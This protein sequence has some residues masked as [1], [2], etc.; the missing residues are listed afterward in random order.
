MHFHGV[1]YLINNLHFKSSFQVLCSY[2]KTK[3]EFLA[4]QLSKNLEILFFKSD[5]QLKSNN[6][7]QANFINACKIR[8]ESIS[9]FPNFEPSQLWKI[10][11]TINFDFVPKTELQIYQKKARPSIKVRKNLWLNRPSRKKLRISLPCPSKPKFEPTD[12]A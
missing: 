2:S 4:T 9:K 5:S 11:I 3:F 6:N 12:P 1:L 10:K 7:L 8:V